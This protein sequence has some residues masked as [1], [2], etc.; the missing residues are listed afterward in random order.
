MVLSLNCVFDSKK[1]EKGFKN[2]E[3]YKFITSDEFLIFVIFLKPFSFFFELKT[4]FKDK[5][6]FI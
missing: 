2:S 5:T 6:I 3:F 4:Q 1:N